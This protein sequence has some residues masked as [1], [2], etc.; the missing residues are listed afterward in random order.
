MRRRRRRLQQKQQQLLLPLLQATATTCSLVELL[1]VALRLALVL[2][3]LSP[4]L[5]GGKDREDAASVAAVAAVGAV[6]SHVGKIGKKGKGRLVVDDAST[7]PRRLVE[8]SSTT[9]RRLLDESSTSRRGV[10]DEW[11]T[12]R[13]VLLQKQPGSTTADGVCCLDRWPCTCPPELHTSELTDG[14][15]R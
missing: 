6:A 9:L 14:R 8:E 10:V 12:R 15:G 3:E 1:S 4:V 13:R 11:L 5:C 7:T 2:A